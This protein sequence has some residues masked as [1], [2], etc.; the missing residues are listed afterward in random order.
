MDL[1]GFG[2][3][4]A[5]ADNLV[6]VVICVALSCIGYCGRGFKGLRRSL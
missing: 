3:F 6:S 2:F 5:D 1:V 4:D